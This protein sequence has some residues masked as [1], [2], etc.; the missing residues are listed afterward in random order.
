M[1][2]CTLDC[3]Y[4]QFGKTA[5]TTIER[6]EYIPIEPILAELEAALAE[7]LEADYITIAGSGEPTLNS[8]LGELIDGIKKVTNIPIAILT[9]GTLL[10]RAEVRADCSKADIVMPSVDAGDERT[11]Q[12]INCPNSVFSV[13]KLISGLCAFREE[14]SGQI[15]LEV[16]FVEG[17]NTGAE[18]IA[19]IKEAIELINPDKV[20]LNTAVR[21]TADPNI[22]RINAEKLQEIADRLGPKCEVVADFSPASSSILSE[23]KSEDILKAHS[24]INSKDEA[25]LSML[26]RRPCSPNDIC[27]GL[28]I[29]R[30][31][32]I[33]H[34]SN[35]LHQG[36]IQSENKE[37]TVFFKTLS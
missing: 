12:R 1:K 33:K 37:G 20:H 18:Q 14:F 34:I 13:E 17:I 24:L 22:A 8:R 26:K 31:E 27:S 11:F 30:N 28:G 10:S 29:N 4:C 25:L 21:P 6:K 7:G 5:Q 2:V 23:S 16:F 9:N 15:W 36:I 35:L 3:I 19:G 32:A